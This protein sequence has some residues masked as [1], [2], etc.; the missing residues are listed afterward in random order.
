LALPRRKHGIPEGK[1]TTDLNKTTVT[2]ENY[3]ICKQL[4]VIVWQ[5][6]KICLTTHSVYINQHTVNKP[7]KIFVLF[8]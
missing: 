3:C 8:K 7:N 2:T 6:G 1:Q 4:K 5:L